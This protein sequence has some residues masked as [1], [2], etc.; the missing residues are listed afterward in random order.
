MKPNTETLNAIKDIEDG[1][2]FRAGNTD[3]LFEQLDS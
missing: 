3:D 2:V 1:K